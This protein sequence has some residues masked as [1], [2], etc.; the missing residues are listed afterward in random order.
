MSTLLILGAAGDLAGRYLLPALAQLAAADALPAKLR[1]RGV[2]REEFDDDGFR[3]H[4]AERLSRH[5]QEAAPEI[6]RKL[7]ARVDYRAADVTD[8]DR[9]LQRS[10]ACP[11]R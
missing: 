9:W 2:S 6:H 5:A 1:I 10:A 3:A 8:Q 7:L 4:A 11:S